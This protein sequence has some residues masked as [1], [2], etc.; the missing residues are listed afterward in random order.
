VAEKT[1]WPHDNDSNVGPGRES[2]D[3]Y[4]S[5]TDHNHE[6]HLDPLGGRLPAQ[7]DLPVEGTPA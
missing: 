1:A 2:T 6:S 7:Q 5:H 4:R 3:G